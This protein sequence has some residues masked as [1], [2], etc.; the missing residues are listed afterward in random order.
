MVS[1]R[2]EGELIAS[3]EVVVAQG[4]EREV[5]FEVKPDE[6]GYHTYE[7]SLPVPPGDTVPTNNRL[8]LTVK[9]VR[10]RTR[11]LQVTSAPYPAAPALTG[12][13]AKVQRRSCAEEKP[14]PV[15]VSTVPPR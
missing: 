13:A 15:N 9:V 1:L 4:E 5:T 7:V 6:I 10:D 12:T 2:G 14:C 11:V 3:Q 8:E